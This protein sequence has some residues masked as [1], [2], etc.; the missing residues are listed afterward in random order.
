MRGSVQPKQGAALAAGSGCC[1]LHAARPRLRTYCNGVVRVTCHASIEHPLDSVLAHEAAIVGFEEVHTGRHLE[2]N[3]AE[4]SQLRT[5]Q[6]AIRE[7]GQVAYPPSSAIICST[8]VP[9]CR[10]VSSWWPPGPRR[11][12][13]PMPMGE[14]MA[15]AACA[16]GRCERQE[17][18]NPRR[19][20]EQNTPAQKHS[21]KPTKH[22]RAKQQHTH[23]CLSRAEGLEG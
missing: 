5:T 10:S 7:Q 21:S 4:S 19:Q 13:L 12:L 9:I 15:A 1:L 2:P 14:A 8:K 3:N 20:Q 17:E 18:G 22:I 16:A 6:Q 23:K 11:R